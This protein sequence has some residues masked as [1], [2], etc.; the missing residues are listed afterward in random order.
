M[1]NHFPDTS[2]H[3][4]SSSHIVICQ[5][6]QGEFKSRGI[7]RHRNKCPKKPRIG[8]VVLLHSPEEH[9]S[10]PAAIDRGTGELDFL[11]V[12]EDSALAGAVDPIM[13]DAPSADQEIAARL[14]QNR[15]SLP[16]KLS[17]I[18]AA[19]LKLQHETGMSNSTLSAVSRFHSMFQGHDG[20]VD[21]LK[22]KK[23][24]HQQTASP[25][26][27]MNEHTVQ[28]KNINSP[29]GEFKKHSNSIPKSVKVRVLKSLFCIPIS[30]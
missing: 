14:E 2:E 6:C 17:D 5:Y 23:R 28:M 29:D 13:N 3:A 10:E 21:A 15:T 24:T 22:L 4:M 27:K 12:E 1:R 18:D 9:P 19:L 25:I 26:P 8:P 30:K 16:D 7:N 11:D 20:S